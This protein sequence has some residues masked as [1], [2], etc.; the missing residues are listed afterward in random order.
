VLPDAADDKEKLDE[1]GAKRQN[2]YTAITE[3]THEE[4]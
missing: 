4:R 1:N 3:N 2:T